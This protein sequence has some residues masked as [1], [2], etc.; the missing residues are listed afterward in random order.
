MFKIWQ[1]LTDVSNKNGNN[2]NSNPVTMLP[3]QGSVG[4]Q[5]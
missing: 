2:Q 1:K 3:T 4:E 5:A